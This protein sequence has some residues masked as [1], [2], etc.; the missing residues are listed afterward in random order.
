MTNMRTL[1]SIKKI[2]YQYSQTAVWQKTGPTASARR[3]RAQKTYLKV[4]LPPTRIFRKNVRLLACIVT[5]V[6]KQVNYG[7][8]IQ[9][10]GPGQAYNPTQA[11]TDYIC[12]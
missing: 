11:E 3:P 6:R 7:M 2:Q 1:I 8:L 9:C 5:R 12:S 10:V 4:N